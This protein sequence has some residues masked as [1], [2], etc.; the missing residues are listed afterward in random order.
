MEQNR[1]L[2]APPESGS[3]PPSST[4]A[5]F[6]IVHQAQGDKKEERILVANR[7]ASAVA[8]VVQ[9]GTHESKSNTFLSADCVSGGIT[10]TLDNN[11]MWNEFYRCSTE[12]VL[13]KQGRRMFPY[14]RYW[15]TGMDP[16]QKYILAMDITPLDT[17][18]YKWNG[19]WWEPGGKAEPHVL[20]RVFIHPESPSTGQYWMHQPVS[21]YKLKLTNNI[22]DQEGH[23]ILHSMHRYLPRLHVIPADKAIEVIQLNGPDVHTFTFP[24]TEFFAVT[25]YQNLQITQ[26]KIDCNP[27]AKGFREGTVVGRPLK[28]VKPKNLAQENDSLGGKNL[29]HDDPE[30]IGKLKEFISMSEQSDADNE[31]ESFNTK[32]ELP[33]LLDSQTTLLE[34]VLQKLNRLDSFGDTSAVTTASLPT[35]QPTIKIK[36][37]P[38]DNYDYDKSI[39][40]I[41]VKQEES[42]DDVTDEYSNS[43]DD[44]PIL[45]RHFAQ[46][47][48]KRRLDRKHSVRSPSG[49]AKAKLLK[50]DDGKMPMVYLESCSSNKIAENVTNSQELAL[51][52]KR[53]RNIKQEE[54]S[55]IS[56]SNIL[57]KREEITRIDR[58]RPIKRKI[59]ADYA[60]PVTVRSNRG[61]KKKVSSVTTKS[62][63]TVTPGNESGV[64]PVVK[65][66]GRPPKNKGGKVGRPPKKKPLIEATKVPDFKPDLEDVD[67]VLF[68]AFS[69]REA[70]DV[71]TVGK[72]KADV[73]SAPP[74][75]PVHVELTEEQ[76]KIVNLEKQLLVQLK[77]MRHRQVIHPALQQVGLRLN[78]VD[79]AMSIDL[80]YL[81]VELPLPFITS[82]SKLENFGISSEGL[83]FV[84]RTG[85]TTDYTKIKGWRD[86]F[87]TNPPL[88]IEAGSS[89]TTLKNRSAF[90]S[91]ELD[92]YL[93][94]EAKLMEDI[95]STSLNETVVTTV[96]FQFPTKSASY[97]RTLDSVLKK[98]A[99]QAA[100][101]SSNVSKPPPLPVKKRKYTRRTATPKMKSKTKPTLPSSPVAQEKPVKSHSP[102]KP[103]SPKKPKLTSSPRAKSPAAAQPSEK[104]PLSPNDVT[105]QPS[106]QP[107]GQN[108]MWPRLHNSPFQY[109]HFTYKSTGFSKIQ[110]KL[111]ELEEFAIRQGK[112]RTYITEERAEIALSTLL[113]V[114]DCVKSKPSNKTVI[115][116][117]SPCKNEFCPLG[118]IC[119]SLSRSKR[120]PVHCRREACMFRCDCAES[121]LHQ[122]T[123]SLGQN[124]DEH[125]SSS[126]EEKPDVTTQ[127]QQSAKYID[128]TK[129]AKK[130]QKEMAKPCI[131]LQG[132]SRDETNIG[133]N[134]TIRRTSADSCFK[135]W[136]P[137][138]FP[139][140]DR[141]D[142]D[143]DPEPVFIPEKGEVNESKTLCQKEQTEIVKSPAS[144]SPH[145]FPPRP[146][147]LSENVDVE[148]VH[149]LNSMTC[150]RARVYNCKAPEDKAKKDHILCTH[151][152]SPGK[153]N[154]H[155]PSK[156]REQE[157]E[158]AGD[159]EVAEKRHKKTES[160][161]PTKLLKI[162]SECNWEQ[163]PQTILNIVPQDTDNK[164]TQSFRVGNLN[165]ELTSRTRDGD[166]PKASGTSCVKISVIQDQKTDQ[167]TAKPPPVKKTESIKLPEQIALET[168]AEKDTKSHG[169]KGLPFYTKVNPAGKLVARLKN[170]TLNQSELIQVYGKGFPQAKFILGQMGA[171]H[172]ENTFPAHF[173]DGL[174]PSLLCMSK[175]N[176]ASAKEAPIMAEPK[177]SSTNRKSKVTTDGLKAEVTL[178]QSKTV[179]PSTPSGVL[180]QKVKG[181]RSLK[182]KSS[183][184]RSPESIVVGLPKMHKNSSPLLL[185]STQVSS[186]SGVTSVSSSS[187]N[188]AS[189]TPLLSGVVSPSKNQAA[190]LPSPVVGAPKL[191]T[192]D[193]SLPVTPTLSNGSTNMVTSPLGSSPKS[194]SIP[195]PALIRAPCPPVTSSSVNSPAY[196]GTNKTLAASLA[197]SLVA[198]ANVPTIGL[199]GSPTG[200]PAVTR[201]VTSPSAASSR[202][203]LTPGPQ[204]KRLGPRLLLI[205]VA[206]GSAPVRP[207]QCV[208]TSPGKKMVLQPI[209]CPNGMNLFRHPN[210]QIIQLVP[211]QQVQSPNV[212]QN[213]R[214]L[215]RTGPPL[216]IQ[217]PTKTKT[218]SSVVAA[219]GSS[220]VPPAP[221][222]QTFSRMS[223]VKS[224]ITVIPTSPSPAATLR[225]GTPPKVST[226][227]S[228]SAPKVAAYSASSCGVITSPNSAIQSGGLPVFKCSKTTALSSSPQDSAANSRIIIIPNK[229]TIVIDS[230]KLIDISLLKFA[231]SEK[232]VDQENTSGF[233]GLSSMETDNTAN[234]VDEQS[235]PKESVTA[236][237]QEVF[238]PSV[239][240]MGEAE[241]STVSS[242]IKVK[243]NESEKSDILHGTILENSIKQC[244]DMEVQTSSQ[245]IPINHADKKYQNDDNQ[246]VKIDYDLE[247][248]AAESA[249]YP[250]KFASISDQDIENP[251]DES[252]QDSTISPAVSDQYPQN[253]ATKNVQNP[254]RP[255]AESIT[256]EQDRVCAIE[257]IYR[258]VQ[259][260]PVSES[261]V[262][263]QA[264][265]NSEQKEE[266]NGKKGDLVTNFTTVNEQNETLPL[267][268]GYNSSTQESEHNSHSEDE[269]E[270]DESV[271]IETVEELSEKTSIA[272]LKAT[273]T[274]VTPQ[275]DTC[276]SIV[277]CSKGRKKGSKVNGDDIFSQVDGEYTVH[278][279]NHTENERKR[280]HEMRDLFEELKNALGLHNLPKVSKSYILK[281]AVEEIEGLTD[282]ADSLI[283]QKTL[284]SQT[285]SQLIK[286]V[287]YLSGKP[288]EVVLKKLE[289]LYAKQNAL[290]AEKKKNT[291][292]EDYAL[293]SSVNNPLPAFQP[294][295]LKNEANESSSSK[296]KPII[297]SGKHALLSAG[298]QQ[299]AVI[300]TP[301]L[302]MT[303]TGQVAAV[304]KPKVRQVTGI[305][306]TL[307]QADMRPA[308]MPAGMASVVIQLPG[309][310]HLKGIIGNS[311]VPITLSAV[312]HTISAAAPSPTKPENDDL[313]MMPRIVNVT[314]LAEETSSDLSQELGVH[315]PVIK[316]DTTINTAIIDPLPVRREPPSPEYVP[317]TSHSVETVQE[318]H[319]SGMNIT[320]GSISSLPEILPLTNI[321]NDNAEASSNSEKA[322]VDASSLTNISGDVR[323]SELE[324]EL[325]KLSS[326]I[327]E[328]ELEPSEL[329]D[330]MGVHEDSDETLTS[331]LNE[332]A[333]LNQQLNNDHSDL[334]CDFSESDTPSRGSVGKSA[335]GDGSPFYFGGFKEL[336]EPKEKDISL[337]PLF[338]QLDEG[339]IQ[340]SVKH[341]EEPG[342]VIYED[343]AKK[344][345]L[346][347]VE[348]DLQP[349]AN[350]AIFQAAD[351]PGVL[352]DSNVFWRPMPKLAP[353]GLKSSGIQS[354]QKPLGNKSM[355]SLAS[356]TVRLSPPKPM[357]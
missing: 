351:K 63:A 303:S 285:Q 225:L 12:M 91:D 173:I 168:N 320:Q 68:V 124:G 25:A 7:D 333:F 292:E 309:T 340:E 182:Q 186:S 115:N 21:F 310:I 179:L 155:K 231:S 66:R 121:K 302:L 300:T 282:A 107:F 81:G 237:D 100:S 147:V 159:S 250:E 28:E 105:V 279:Q 27:F 26:L 178:P 166:T 114:Q 98:Q 8:P 233:K 226:E 268:P 202:V 283:K 15:V 228:P 31:N 199:V 352:S 180:T 129:E 23:I 50:L 99:L 112:P 342:I 247:A 40:G 230:K 205:P 79:H 3:K 75:P 315:T 22:L 185:A 275:N 289:Y 192:I 345:A 215:I 151:S 71:H 356:A 58:K 1:M 198:S 45:E 193:S 103:K 260:Q 290:E 280:R 298:T 20:G 35:E 150:A 80:R 353:L 102:H 261:E 181:D 172:S 357:D 324:L 256:L 48:A 19:K 32:P 106:V 212:Q 62:K 200:R 152:E 227:T 306:P 162:V 264:P 254:K 317:S 104:L 132:L 337:S 251:G 70:L 167:V 137:K 41:Q 122:N 135:L 305:P 338:L 56:P 131:S 29:E 73:P 236:T 139:I 221:A 69:S 90:C 197:S 46:F 11:N 262:N 37:E 18:K 170:S 273:A 109:S 349:S 216:A 86:K 266:E 291:L 242:R 88:K 34:N 335:D 327:D 344:E 57:C 255:K 258:T 47:S 118:C 272:H 214:F 287:S 43:D 206:N 293:I 10:V 110:M 249:H 87:S 153:E 53:V 347:K 209:K 297:I 176:E 128:L 339:E 238:T 276:T 336:S 314:S 42:D 232:N 235:G 94:N 149:N 222:L 296:A 144:K 207:V 59:Y 163:D 304:T 5:Y 156:Y 76:K 120:K 154:S 313:S 9:T 14:C 308:Q 263:P 253:P 318:I 95:K 332:I 234:M 195:P 52:H 49:V 145:L 229:P 294:L 133:D 38:E 92:E 219:T 208:P 307:M 60:V 65:R 140:W 67:G 85:K 17:H 194:V 13:T 24:Q 246:I 348:N 161:S 323:D 334:G 189:A 241:I 201:T 354:D 39:M 183:E 248:P 134:K 281:K 243:I 316:A 330:V 343:V 217:R 299:A 326:A 204:D 213:Q 74:D 16:F 157:K 311:S 329:S 82:D 252:V 116:R 188:V 286:K 284:V 218:D 210:G 108:S 164:E 239:E 174:R 4:P 267:D 350:M 2:E 55:N 322:P 165:I 117:K 312:P 257:S 325:K 187:G 123:S 277:K 175:T 130:S 72:P 211:L 158:N 184:I 142:V 136:S 97:V 288:K 269:S 96:N 265:S 64:A 51:S 30:I 177:S 223:P 259:V 89:E 328:A 295:R 113:T 244:T 44:Y 54:D 301:N 319:F 274:S 169:G 111:Q 125:M 331:L 271:D 138:R 355:P 33:S 224:G 341:S 78:I 6:V 321:S 148:D 119:S 83:P 93:E 220:S 84:S 61:R 270:A 77:T 191:L 196:P 101:N 127:G 203:T 240:K 146:A 160:S 141:S 245:T 36:E 346:T 143:N 171:L 278:R 190:S 126:T